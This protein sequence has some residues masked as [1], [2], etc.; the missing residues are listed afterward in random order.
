MK[1]IEVSIDLPVILR[2]HLDQFIKPR[3]IPTQ[4]ELNAYFKDPDSL[5]DNRK[6]VVGKYLTQR[7]INTVIEEKESLVISDWLKPWVTHGEER[8]YLEDYYADQVIDS[9]PGM[10]E[11]AQSLIAVLVKR[12]PSEEIVHSLREA[13]KSYV[14][15]LYV[16]CVCICRC[17]LEQ[18]LDEELK[19]TRNKLISIDFYRRPDGRPKSPFEILIDR[20]LHEKIL[21]SPGAII[22]RRIIKRGNEAAHEGKASEDVAVNSLS[23]LQVLLRDYFLK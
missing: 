23:D 6:D 9:L 7:I 12:K 5:G 11:R 18:L 13:F 19:G 1:T 21:D 17:V 14:N 22:A 4:D 15:G 3:E 20:A 10:V 2:E 16:A 8:L